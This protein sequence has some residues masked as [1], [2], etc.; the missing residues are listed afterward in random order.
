MRLKSLHLKMEEDLFML[1]PEEE[2]LSLN[3][4]EYLIE[5]L[6]LDVD[7]KDKK[8]QTPLYNAISSGQLDT[9]AYLLE[10]G[11]NA[12]ASDDKNYTPLHCAAQTG[13]T[14]I[15]TLL[16]SRGVR[17]D[18]ACTSG[19]ALLFAAANGHQDA[20]KVLLDHGANPNNAANSDSI[21]KPLM[22][23]IEF[24]SWECMELLL[25]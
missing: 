13:R 21:P 3:V 16:L 20:V 10:K 5:T 19:T 4:C 7:F 17:V 1:L 15:I 2:I 8:G 6:K 9:F 18:V 25:Q 12:D 14:K 22:A 23:A 24:K 11:A